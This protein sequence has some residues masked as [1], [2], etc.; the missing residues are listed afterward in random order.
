[1]IKSGRYG[2]YGEKKRVEKIKGQK[3]PLKRT[4]ATYKQEEHIKISPKHPGGGRK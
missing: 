4:S 1:M 2:K 3:K